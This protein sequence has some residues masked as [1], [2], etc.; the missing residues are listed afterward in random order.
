MTDPS[1]IYN[2]HHSSRQ[3]QILNLLSEARDWT[4]IHVDSSQIPRRWATMGT[5]PFLIFKETWNKHGWNQAL[6]MKG[7]WEVNGGNETEWRVGG[8]GWPGM[9]THSF[10]N[11]AKVS[12]KIWKSAWKAPIFQ[13]YL[14]LFLK[15]HW[16]DQ[17]TPGSWLQPWFGAFGIERR[18]E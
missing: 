6:G 12:Q 4:C 10:R 7:Q 18:T 2:L 13:W 14:E 3:R 16:P 1:H 15:L 11:V 5:P 9:Q 8:S 17:N